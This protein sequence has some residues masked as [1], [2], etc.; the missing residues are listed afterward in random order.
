LFFLPLIITDSD[1]RVLFG[2]K[3][4]VASVTVMVDYGFL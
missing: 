2:R 1:V 3:E 4:T